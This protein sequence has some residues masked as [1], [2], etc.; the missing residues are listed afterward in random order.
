MVLHL[1]RTMLL[2]SHILAHEDIA[3]RYQM[4]KVLPLVEHGGADSSAY[5]A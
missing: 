1:T 5:H 4:I 3:P 2:P